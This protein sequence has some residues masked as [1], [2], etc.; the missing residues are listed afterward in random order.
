MNLSDLKPTQRH[1]V[2]D[3]VL[4][5]GLDVSD[6]ANYR[7][8]EHPSSNPKY[9]YNL[10]F[11]GTDRVVLCLW[12]E[13]IEEDDTGVFQEL[14]YREIKTDLDPRAVIRQALGQILEYAYHPLRY[15]PRPD[16][17]VIVGRSPLRPEDE[18]YLALL[19]KEFR[20]PLTYRVIEI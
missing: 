16:R 13:E 18:A 5:A 19:R 15:G 8:S 7:R 14:N 2:Y 10:A 1:R 4:D 3:L 6:W 12:F 17:L 20:I 11:E 9:C